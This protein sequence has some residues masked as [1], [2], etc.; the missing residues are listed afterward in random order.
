MPR[1]R[2]N[3][4]NVLIKRREGDRM[5]KAKGRGISRAI[6][7]SNT[8]KIT[9]SKKNRREKGSRADVFGSNPHS[10]GDFFSRSWC[11]RIDTENVV[12]T[13][14]IAK[15]RAIRKQRWLNNISLRSHIPST[16]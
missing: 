16:G 7:M 5:V 2:I 9:V 12:S 6:S 13:R 14:A 4:N 3:K 15:N 10:N 8:R 11:L 1:V